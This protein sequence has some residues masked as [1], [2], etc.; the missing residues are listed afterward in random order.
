MAGRKDGSDTSA[1]PALDVALRQMALVDRILGLEA[2]VARLKATTTGG[3]GARDEIS[4]LEAEL[5]AVY[6]SRTWAAGK[7][8]TGLADRL[9]HPFGSRT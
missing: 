2:E 3:N 9:R 1:D 6:A 5:G 7:A 8:L 4:R